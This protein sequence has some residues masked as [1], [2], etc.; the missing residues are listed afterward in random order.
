[1]ILYRDKEIELDESV[2]EPNDSVKEVGER[3]IKW[4]VFHTLCFDH[5]SL[6]RERHIWFI[7]KG[8]T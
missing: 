4:H 5:F 1:M 6:F 2:G 7:P 3:E 8:I